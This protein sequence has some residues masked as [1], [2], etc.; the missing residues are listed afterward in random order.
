MNKKGNGKKKASLPN[1]PTTQKRQAEIKDRLRKNHALNGNNKTICLTMIVRNEAKNMIRLL[2]SLKPIIDCASIVDTGSTDDTIEVIKKWSQDNN[3]EIKVHSEPFRDFGRNRTHSF[4]MA[5]QSFPNVDYALLSDADFVWEIDVVYKFDKRLLIDEIYKVEQY[6]STMKYDNIRL[7]KMNLDFVCKLRTH[8]YWRLGDETY[9]NVAPHRIIRTLRIND[10]EDGGCKADKYERDERLLLEDINDP[11]NT[12]EDVIRAKFY[13]AQTYRC[14][15]RYE[16]S[17]KWYQERAGDPGW[18]Q[19][20]WYSK[21]QVGFCYEKWGWKIKYCKDLLKKTEREKCD[22]EY[23]VKWNKD[24]WS[25]DDLLKESVKLF[26]EAA[27]HYMA[28]YHARPTRA[29]PIYN[30]V[31]MY[32]QLDDNDMRR[33]AYDFSIIGKKIPMTT[34][35]LFVES[36]CYDYLFDH[37]IS[38]CAWYFPDL[39]DEGREALLR[40]LDRNDLPEKIA[41]QAKKNACHYL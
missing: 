10:K 39:R 9:R 27:K 21:F 20:I 11:E 33:K 31:R 6:N 23:L 32:R 36:A 3:I 8:E 5:Q 40:L 25:I 26:A 13:L 12:K 35:T 37:E 30:C 22:D 15:D 18:D 34:D 7:L 2:D 19:E 1:K 41:S 16:E 14:L 38:I 28:A 17:I 24:N 29:E 4:K